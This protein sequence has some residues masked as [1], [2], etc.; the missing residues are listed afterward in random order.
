MG[1][2]QNYTIHSLFEEYL[3]VNRFVNASDKAWFQ[4]TLTDVINDT[5]SEDV[6]SMM[7]PVPHFVDYMRDA[8]E[9]EIPDD[10]DGPADEEQEILA[11][12]IYE[13]VRI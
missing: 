10:E 12:K 9:E 8:P 1:V 6:A 5:V 7:L 2:V 3:F 4:K 13:L 11:P